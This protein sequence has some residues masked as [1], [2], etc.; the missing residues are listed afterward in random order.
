MA[1]FARPSADTNNPGTY[2][3]Q[4]GGGTNIYTTID[5]TAYSD[6]DYI[7]STLNPASAVYVTELT[8]LEDP[9]SSAGHTLR[10]RYAKDVTG[11]GQINLTVQLRQGYV[12]EVTLGA[13]IAER[14]FTN[15]G[16][17]FTTDAYTLTAG[18]A[19]AITDYT[20]LFLRTVATQV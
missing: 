2:T 8:N 6:A 18:E 20:S 7:R 4:A 10:V 9:V 17:T 15:I 19:D 3:D 5:E 13:L 1:Q 12:S 14:T 11:G 16:I